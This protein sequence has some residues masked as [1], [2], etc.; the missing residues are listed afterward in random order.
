MKKAI[1]LV[2]DSLGIGYAPDALSFGDQGANTFGHVMQDYK[3][4]NGSYPKIPN[5][6]RLGLISAANKVS[7]EKLAI[8]T[9]KIEG[10]YGA[11]KELS[12]G[13]DTPSGH[14]EMAGLPVLKDWGY[15]P[16]TDNCFPANFVRE[17]TEEAGVPGIIGNCH[18]SG[19]D[20]IKALG[21]E[22]MRSGKPICYTS[23]D[24]VFQVACHEEIF[25]LEKLFSFCEIARD[26]LYKENIGR[27]I[28]RPFLGSKSDNFLRTGNRK[29][30]S[31]EPETDTLL[32]VLVAND[33]RVA[34]VGKI[35]DIFA[36][37]GISTST[38]AI[39]LKS[40]IDETLKVMEESPEETLVF[41]NL[42]DFDQEYG[43]RRDPDG[44]CR[45]LCYLDSRID[46][47][48][49]A[50]S[51]DDLLIISADHGCDP[52]WEG[53]DHTREFVPIIAYKK[54]IGEVDLGVRD[55]FADVGQ[56][57]ASFFKVP[58]LQIGRCFL[59]SLA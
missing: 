7:E 35:S 45:A 10:A 27:V 16:K 20:I 21:E 2:A 28:A 53:T 6:C 38:K 43:H 41:T 23:G 50:M 19:T 13:K 42:V 24:S 36:H 47:I 56:T 5:L 11:A 58:P 1:L 54:G 40:L 49:E 55:T 34:A 33:K 15:F 17:L 51:H 12:N 44:Y 25:G 4:K 52:T 46:D 8:E 14:W 32:D 18:A 31:I 37:K 9:R 30:Y 22:H 3:R 48:K 59:D 29:D 26:L 57:L 39:G